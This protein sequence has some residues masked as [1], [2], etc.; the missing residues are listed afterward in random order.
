MKAKVF[1]TET[2]GAADGPGVRLVVFF[3]GCS[4]RCAYCHNPES[5]EH[6]TKD[7][8][9]MSIKDIVK[10]YQRNKP[11]Y[12]NGGI[13]VSGGEPMLQ[14]KFIL[15]LAKVCKRKHIRLAIDTAATNLIGNEKIYKKVA[16]YADLWI[17]DI[18]GVDEKIHQQVTGSTSLTGMKLIKLL[19]QWKKPYWVRYVLVNKLTD[20]PVYL[21]TLGMFLST[22]QYM[23]NYE[24]LPYHSMA[25]D[26]YKK[27]KISYWLKDT[28]VMT[29]DENAKALEIVKQAF[30]KNKKA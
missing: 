16:K 8:Y 9:S 1:K 23:Q 30:A 28:R 3:Q 27:L 29:P 24:L 15:K 10:L 14:H 4:F 13:T 17:V 21:Q 11:F 22:L 26:K 20:S 2:F 6:F 12:Q 5:W 7:T 25:L 19:E 18:K